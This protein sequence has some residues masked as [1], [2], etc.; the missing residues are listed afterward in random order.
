[1]WASDCSFGTF[2]SASERVSLHI[3]SF[4]FL[5]LLFSLRPSRPSFSYSIIPSEFPSGSRIRSNER[6][7]VCEVV[8]RFWA[9]CKNTFGLLVRYLPLASLK[10]LK[11]LREPFQRGAKISS[12]DYV[13]G[14]DGVRFHYVTALLHWE[15]NESAA[16]RKLMLWT[17]VVLSRKKKNRRETWKGVWRLTKNKEEKNC[18]EERKKPWQM[19]IKQIEGR[20]KIELKRFGAINLETIN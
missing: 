8:K 12:S 5:G 16:R 7:Y 20:M 11:I 9:W 2:F 3:S 15:N 4:L 17:V 18:E 10:D 13:Q 19:N 14:S 1:M 6:S